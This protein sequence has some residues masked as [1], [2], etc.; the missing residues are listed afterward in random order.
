MGAGPNCLL[1]CVAVFGA[2]H[3]NCDICAMQRQRLQLQRGYVLLLLRQSVVRFTVT[4]SGGFSYTAGTSGSFGC[5]EGVHAQP[6]RVGARGC[7]S[8]RNV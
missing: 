7:G 2:P 1:L 5:G 6:G 3:V 8:K 4:V